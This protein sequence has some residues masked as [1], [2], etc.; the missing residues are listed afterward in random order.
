VLSLNSTGPTP[1][2]TR[3]SSPTSARGSEVGECRAAAVG[4]P[5]RARPVQLADKVHGLL[6]DRRTFPREDV[7]W[8]CVRVYTRVRVLYT[9][10]CIHLQH[11]TI[12]ASLKSVSVSV[13]WNLSFTPLSPTRLPTKSQHAVIS[14]HLNV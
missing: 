14:A 8:G 2:P 1:T 5:R 10:N 6:S 4:L 9:I 11:Y 3:T 13:Q 12:G 7:R